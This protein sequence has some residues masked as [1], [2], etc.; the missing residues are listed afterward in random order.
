MNKARAGFSLIELMVVVAI[1]A[2]LAT[3]S[4]PLYKT[5]LTKTRINSM[6][7][8]MEKLKFNALEYYNENGVF[9]NAYQLGLSPIDDM[10]VENPTNYSP[11]ATAIIVRPGSICD[12]TGKVLVLLDTVKLGLGAGVFYFGF[13][14]GEKNGQLITECGYPPS[15]TTIP[16]ANRYLSSNCL[17][18]YD[19]WSAVE[20]PYDGCS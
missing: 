2:I 1:V 6:F 17:T 3:A 13:N 10:F 16:D 14:F 20:A 8:I 5:Q 15:T 9:P 11:Y 19:D 12:K 7:P 18:N 4:V